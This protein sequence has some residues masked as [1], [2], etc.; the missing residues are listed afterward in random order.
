[1]GG[2][3]EVYRLPKVGFQGEGYEPNEQLAAHASQWLAREGITERI[4]ASAASDGPAV[5]G[6]YGA[7]L[8]GWA[9]YLHINGRSSAWH[10]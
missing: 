2:G 3:S 1:M 9:R 6:P 4:L 10:S 7:V 8:V 5:G